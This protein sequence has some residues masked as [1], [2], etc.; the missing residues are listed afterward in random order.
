M[1]HDDEM[2]VIDAMRKKLD[3]LPAAG[4]P[5]RSVIV[6]A[7]RRAALVTAGSAAAVVLG[8]GGIVLGAW[9]FEGRPSEGDQAPAVETTPSEPPS[10][11]SKTE[12][13]IVFSPWSSQSSNEGNEDIAV[14]NADGTEWH[15]VIDSPRPE[16]SASWSPDKER[17]VFAAQDDREDDSHIFVADRN[18][19]NV[20]QVTTGTPANDGDPHWSPDGELIA[21]W[22]TLY[23]QGDVEIFTVRPDG[24]EL[25]QVTDMEGI[26]FSPEWSPDGERLAFTFNGPGDQVD[27]YIVD[28]EGGDPI[29]ITDGSG[30]F[31]QPAWSPDGR[32]I[33]MTEELSHGEPFSPQRLV[34]ID[35]GTGEVRELTSWPDE[36]G[37]GFK[38]SE[39]R[40]LTWVDER[41][42]GFSFA[43]NSPEK[44]NNVVGLFDVLDGSMSELPLAAPG[45]VDW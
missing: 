17:I 43:Q 39:V 10:D 11:G 33:A 37:P 36:T 16:Y 4:A 3:R 38:L 25:T 42:L 8:L 14:A 13:A 44:V 35:V 32:S 15:Y 6:R 7:R 20:R 45:G 30:K 24:S 26:S 41:T 1:K 18:G 23:P 9:Q 29:R 12:G 34:A 21:F 28:L 27:L 40:S 22:R 5:A 19:A 2:S 31:G